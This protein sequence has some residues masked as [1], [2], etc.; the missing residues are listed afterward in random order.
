MEWLK[1]VLSVVWSIF[2]YLFKRVCWKNHEIVYINDNKKLSDESDLINSFQIAHHKIVHIYSDVL[3]HPHPK[4]HLFLM[5][6]NLK[7]IIKNL[8]K[9]PNLYYYGFASTPLAIYDGYR[10]TDKHPVNLCDSRKDK[11]KVYSVSVSRK[12]TNKEKYFIRKDNAINLLVESSRKIHNDLIPN[13]FPVYR[14]GIDLIDDRITSNYLN[15]LY[16]KMIDFLDSASDAGVK[17]IHLFAASRQIVS[18]VLGT[19]IQS[20]HPRIIVYEFDGTKYT[21]YLDLKKGKVYR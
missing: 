8:K 15:T 9:Q 1:L 6:I 2:T 16:F 18:F 11:E 7:L 5:K 21:W 3:S 13:T 14:L 19:A 20:R 4:M 17:E 10:I 12:R